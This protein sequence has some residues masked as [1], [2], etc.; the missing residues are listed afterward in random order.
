MGEI[1]TQFFVSFFFYLAIPFGIAVLLRKLRISPM[2]GFIIGGMIVGNFFGGL[3]S[4]D[5]VNGFAY[6]GIIMLL[7]VIGL[8]INFEKIIAL[9]K[10]IFIAGF[11]QIIASIIFISIIGLLFSF[12]PLQAILIGIAAASSSTNIVAKL[13]QERGEEHSLLGELSIGIL[14]FQDLAFIPFVIFFTVVSREQITAFTFV[15]DII[16]SLGQAVV[17]LSALYVIG[18]MIVP[19]MFDR[20]ARASRDLLNFFE[21]ATIF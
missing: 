21:I 17:I 12:T 20:I 14:L 6:F 9:K 5:T 7:F 19:G 18:R 1:S 8:E 4:R 10:F 16:F 3:L 11:A 2:L 13:I 15:R